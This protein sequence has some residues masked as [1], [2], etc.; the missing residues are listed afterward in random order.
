MATTVSTSFTAVGSSV[1]LPLGAYDELLTYNISGTYA[2]TI[3][4]DRAVTRDPNGAWETV[5]GPFST[6]NAT[7]AG[8][9]YGKKNHLYRVRC[10]A[11]TSGT[12]VTTLADEDAIIKEEKDLDGN[13]VSTTT[14]GGAVTL[15]GAVTDADVDTLPIT[16]DGGATV[17][18]SV[19]GDSFQKQVVITLTDT[20]LAI[21]DALAYGSTALFTFPEGR[22]QL[23]GVTS[24]LAFAVTSAR[25]STINDSAAFD[26]A[27][28]TAAASATALTGT[29]VDVLPQQDKL[30]DGAVAAYTT[31]LGAPRASGVQFDGT[32][33][34][35]PVFLNGSFPTGTD[36]DGDGTMTVQGTITITFHHLGDYT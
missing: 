6:A 25:A 2:A 30:L 5:A 18:Q 22:I 17:T 7:V 23:V 20:P 27:L 8:T 35:T 19:K 12:A 10:T 36:I 31:A 3:V 13:V 21:T 9:V 32:T 14:Q 16:I 33:T 28:G 34:P 15:A 26:Y 1:T 11:F 29:M 4:I 24:S